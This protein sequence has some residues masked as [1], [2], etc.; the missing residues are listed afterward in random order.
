MTPIKDS[1]LED[2]SVLNG[3][4]GALDQGDDS[5]EGHLLIQLTAS[6][7]PWT[8]QGILPASALQGL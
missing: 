2:P 8:Y 3:D 7:T 6:C 4:T 5:P 1:I